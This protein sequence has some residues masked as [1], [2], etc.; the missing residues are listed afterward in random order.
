MTDEV[1]SRF[2]HEDELIGVSFSKGLGDGLVLT[3]GSS[4]PMPTN[5]GEQQDSAEYEQ[6]CIWPTHCEAGARFH[7][8]QRHGEFGSFGTALHVY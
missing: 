3:L 6:N 5:I 7:D 4:L 8:L 2:A 1:R